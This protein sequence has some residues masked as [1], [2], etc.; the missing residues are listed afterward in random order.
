MNNF[1]V[2]FIILI[3]YIV[4]FIATIVTPIILCSDLM[5]NSKKQI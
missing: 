4:V 5:L 2:F 1:L 3:F